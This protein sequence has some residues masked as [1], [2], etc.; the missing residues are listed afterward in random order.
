MSFRNIVSLSR[1][2][3]GWISTIAAFTFAAAASAAT[4]EW[5][6][7]GNPGN[8]PD[9]LT[10]YGAVPYTFSIGTYDVT[11]SQYVEFLNAK[12]P[13]GT[14]T[15]KLYSPRMSGFVAG[16]RSYVYGGIDFTP[17]NAVGSKYS[18]KPG[19]AKRPATFI[20][21]NS[22]MRFAN[23]VNNGQGPA[24][25]ENGAY[26]LDALNADSSPVN[27]RITHNPG[28]TVW[29][30]T[31]NEWYKAAHHGNT[32]SS[33]S[34][35]F[36]YPTSSSKTPVG[37]MPGALPN[38]VNAWPVDGISGAQDVPDNTT[39]VGAYSGTRS[40]YGV[41]DMGGNVY[42]W[43]ETVAEATIFYPLGRI[44]RGGSFA[45]STGDLLSTFRYGTPGDL[46]IFINMGFRL[47]SSLPGVVAPPLPP[48]S[49]AINS[50][51][52][53]IA[54]GKGVITS[55]DATINCGAVCKATVAAGTM[56]TL[57]VVPDAGLKFVS[58]TGACAGVSRT[59]AV[60]VTG[61]VSAQANLSK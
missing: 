40:P 5:S 60:K 23:W 27:P 6:S 43:S 32:D 45:G 1:L 4:F 11:V 19:H 31:E 12:D 42:Q 46:D 44:S 24:D 58:W 22:A 35:Y 55:A 38:R 17:G 30:P 39:D 21:F 28:A 14:N 13:L 9:P 37:D 53:K 51:E 16:F 33:S 54:G 20:S 25:T 47:A 2:S 52:V 7:V 41:Y 56:I 57:T 3:R 61:K 36:K 59:C 8:A 34:G 50:I 29:I 48:P 26:T 49:S 18:V 10:G 15:L